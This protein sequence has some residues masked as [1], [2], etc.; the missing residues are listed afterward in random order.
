LKTILQVDDDPNDVY[1]L[2]HAMR[3]VGILN[4]VQVVSDGRQAI[5][6]LQGAGKFADRETFPYP[7]LVLIDLKLPYVM[8]LDVLRWIRRQPR[9]SLMVIMLTASA[10]DADI[11]EAY[12]LGANAFLTKPSEASKLEDMVAAIKAFWLT[13]NTLPPDPVPESRRQRMLSPIALV[14][15]TPVVKNRLH[16][17]RWRARAINGNGPVDPPLAESSS[18]QQQP[19]ARTGTWVPLTRRQTEV[20]QRIARGS[21]SREIAIE[22]AVSLKTVEKHRQA[23][24]DKLGMHEIATLT[25]YAVSK[26]LVECSLAPINGSVGNGRLRHG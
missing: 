3:K 12:R 18:E 11:T 25:R 4:P 13:H 16:S 21:S 6:Y 26:G 1:L 19:Q 9:T 5:H 24:M 7:C 17:D 14:G 10:E 23:L 15:T 2:R 20:L 22:L 8:G